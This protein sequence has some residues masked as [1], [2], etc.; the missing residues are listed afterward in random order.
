MNDDS[1]TLHAPRPSRHFWL[2][3]TAAVIFLPLGF[4]A[5]VHVLM[6]YSAQ[7]QWTAAQRRLA[8]THHTLD[9]M[10][11]VPPPVPDAENFYAIPPLK[12][13]AVEDGKDEPEGAA[14]DRR[15]RLEDLKIDNK[16]S[17]A[18][19]PEDRSGM[20][21][22]L[23]WDAA[24]WAT[25]YRD[26]KILPVP[27]T[28]GNPG[29]DILLG[30]AAQQPL[31]DEL[32]AGID[33]KYSQTTPAW[34]DRPQ[35]K[36][37][38]AVPV[39][40]LTPTQQAV[41]CLLLHAR[42]AAAAGDTARAVDDICIL[43]RLAEG[44]G[45]EPTFLHTLIATLF[46]TMAIDPA[47]AVLDQRTAD[48]ATL[49]RL[50]QCLERVDVRSIVTTGVRGEMAVVAQSC[51]SLA[52]TSPSDTWSLLYPWYKDTPATL[53]ERVDNIMS[54][55]GVLLNPPAA[56]MGNK[57]VVADVMLTHLIEPVETGGLPA[58]RNSAA[59][60]DSES[61]AKQYA[62]GIFGLVASSTMTA[63]QGIADRALMVQARI[64]Q[65]RIAC[66]LER[67]F[68]KHQAYPDQLSALVP[69]YLPAVPLDPMDARP[70][71]YQKTT[72][73][74]YKLWSLGFDG[75]DDGGKVIPGPK[76]DRLKP[77]LKASDYPGDWVWSYE[78]LVPV[79]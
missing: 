2:W 79:E 53:R 54:Y 75:D 38:L 41:R 39:L 48:D 25:F 55:T 51:D 8:D 13:I 23:R 67:H 46:L 29:R 50:E 56:A 42:A 1:A 6:G 36:L 17:T 34:K 59:K 19:L 47:W 77:K 58:L 9:F 44:H 32:K 31:L 57:A 62:P 65:A 69:Q 15:E 76:D 61:A 35:P 73:G 21:H 7:Q 45:H 5:L 28:T 40:Y 18:T 72:A 4:I 30:M 71:R 70:M 22:G 43:V 63:Y 24:A 49:V 74:R 12:N 37:L 68:I 33:R 27:A 20:D 10:A 11:L 16:S 26:S 66:A 78:P 60:F 64:N 3:I 14:T 52:T